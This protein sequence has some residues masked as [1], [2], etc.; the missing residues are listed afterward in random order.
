MWF[1]DSSWLHFDR[2]LQWPPLLMGDLCLKIC[3]CIEH[4][5]SSTIMCQVGAGVSG[6]FSF[7]AMKRHVA[8]KT[9]WACFYLLACL[10]VCLICAP[11]KTRYQSL[12]CNGN[13][14]AVQWYYGFLLPTVT[15]GAGHPISPEILPSAGRPNQDWWPGV[16]RDVGALTWTATLCSSAPL[17]ASQG[18]GRTTW[19]G[20]GASMTADGSCLAWIEHCC[21]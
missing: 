1:P 19:H 14:W 6:W 15:E 7:M 18:L 8:W 5:S 21:E 12:V 2:I 4:R 11:L 9:V 3:S 17:H 20:R 10:L 13:L 16:R